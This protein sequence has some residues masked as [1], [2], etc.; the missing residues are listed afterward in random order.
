MRKYYYIAS[1][2]FVSIINCLHPVSEHEI[3]TS[4]F[5]EAYLFAGQ[6]VH[7]ISVK[8][9]LHF[10]SA[11]D[12]LTDPVLNQESH[13]KYAVVT[14]ISPDNDY[15]LE[16]VG[17]SHDSTYSC[18]HVVE[19][20]KVY[21]IKV[22]ILDSTGNVKEK[23]SAV[24]TVPKRE[25]SL[26]WDKDTLLVDSANIKDKY[27]QVRMN[28]QEY[29]YLTLTMNSGNQK[30]HILHY[31]CVEYV[32]LIFPELTFLRPLKTSPFKGNTGYVFLADVICYGYYMASVYHVNKEYVNLYY[33]SDNPEF[34]INTDLYTESISNV[35]NGCGI[36]TG[37]S[38]DTLYFTIAPE[39]NRNLVLH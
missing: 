37:V 8:E 20:G 31:E 26:L 4:Y 6:P 32:G 10:K 11:D 33:D 17:S 25:M 29:P 39:L 30:Y 7:G 18:I 13:V 34:V 36:F 16:R 15:T 35:E 2:L 22:S 28:Q 19:A 27:L 9:I 3:C 14:L 12:F 38:C 23:L 5:L 1:V 21:K 24:T